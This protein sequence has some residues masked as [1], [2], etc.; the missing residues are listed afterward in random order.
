MSLI[1]DR[2]GEAALGRFQD[3]AGHL[4]VHAFADSDAGLETIIAIHDTSLGPALGGCRMWAYSHRDAAIK[5]VLRL[6]NGM[7]FKN[8]LAGLDFGGGKAVIIADPRKHKTPEL[9]RAF[10][11]A[12]ESLSGRYITAEDVGIT[13]DDMAMNREQRR[14]LQRQGQMDDEGN[15]IAS[16]RDP[17][18]TAPAERATPRQYFSE[19]NSEL[20]RVSWPTRS[21]VIN[22]TIVVLVTLA[23]VTALIA[24]LDFLFREGV[25]QLLRL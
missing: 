24:L 20:R 17:K 19:V 2:L 22:Y 14:Y 4:E 18:A 6:S 9:F 5:D 8:A 15:P 23:F 13:A 3:F 10:G 1:S 21:E 25:L 11:Q 7:T 16:R 12:V